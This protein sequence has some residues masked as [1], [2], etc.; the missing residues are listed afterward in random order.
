MQLPQCCKIVTFDSWL[1]AGTDVHLLLVAIEIVALGLPL[2]K[3]QQQDSTN[4]SFANCLAE[5]LVSVS[6]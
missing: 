1:S 3:V 4:F 6:A 5:L 2:P